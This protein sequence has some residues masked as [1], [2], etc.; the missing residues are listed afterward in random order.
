MDSKDLAK[1]RNKIKGDCG[2]AITISFLKK[3]GYKILETNYK[4]KIG[5]IDIIALKSGVVCFVEVKRRSTL[6][7]GRPIEAVDHKK[8]Q[9]IRR[10]AEFY[11]MVKHKTFADVRF[12]V[13]EIVG[14]EISIVENAF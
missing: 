2:E 11:L 6:A 14:D 8:Q 12:D 10:V 4:N 3:N 5:E 1:V 13:V 9:K 7:F